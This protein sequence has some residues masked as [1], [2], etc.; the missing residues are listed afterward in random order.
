MSLVTRPLIYGTAPLLLPHGPTVAIN[1]K[2]NLRGER[3]VY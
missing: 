2:M 1:T 3:R